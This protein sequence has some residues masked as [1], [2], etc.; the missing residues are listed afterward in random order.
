MTQDDEKGH[1]GSTGV[2]TAYLFWKHGR[3]NIRT[4]VPT[5]L[6]LL[7]VRVISYRNNATKRPAQSKRPLHPFRAKTSTIW[8]KRPLVKQN[9]NKRT[10]HTLNAPPFEF[11][12]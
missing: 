9:P 8:S 6:I 1:E 3:K 11:L 12:E 7:T 2:V 4:G 5:D 10:S